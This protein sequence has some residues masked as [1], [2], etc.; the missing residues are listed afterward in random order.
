M[1]GC[2]STTSTYNASRGELLDWMNG[3]LGIHYTKVEEA[4]NGAALCQ[5]FDVLYPT[6]VKLHKVNF[7]AITEPEMISNYKILQEVFNSERISRNIPV[8]VLIKG[9]CQAALEM[10]QW[11]KGYFDQNFTG[12]A[13]NG[14]HRRQEVGIKDPGD[15]SKAIKKPFSRPAATS[16]APKPTATP[17]AARQVQIAPATAIKS[18]QTPRP[19][20]QL[21]LAKEELEKAK[22]DNQSLAE[23]RNFYYDKLQRVEALC[24]THGDDDFANEIL[25]ILYET[26]EARGFVS[27][28]ELDI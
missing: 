6:K 11:V 8:E 3:L 28:D 10:L 24:Q 22:K 13:Y 9:R 27:P 5:I 20:G 21:Q 12:S 16:R 14:S 17:A 4:S 15:N 18:K 23:E 19:P 26:D 1:K 7:N 25:A 2:A